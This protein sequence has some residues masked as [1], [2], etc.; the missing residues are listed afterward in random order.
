MTIRAGYRIATGTAV[1]D[2]NT[3]RVEAGVREL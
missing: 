1:G 2:A 3:S